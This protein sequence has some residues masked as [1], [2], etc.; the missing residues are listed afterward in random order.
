MLNRQ[1]LPLTD[2][3]SNLETFDLVVMKGLLVT[4]QEAQAI[5]NSNWSHVGMVVVAGDLQI[6]G[7]DPTA[8]L[9]W[10]AN[11]AD[12]ATDLLSNT[13]KAGPQLVLLSDRIQHN[14]WVKYDGAYM[15]RKLMYNRTPDMIDGLK[16]VINDAK[17]G[18]LP[19]TGRD[20]TAELTNFLEGRFYNIASAA[21]QY[22][23]S[24]LVAHTYMALGLLSQ[25]YVSNSYVPADFTEEVDV[26]LLK[27]A[28]L[29]REI[30]LDTNTIAP[31]PPDYKPQGA[32]S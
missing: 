28:W 29:G 25:Y 1:P 20:Q 17:N 10:E 27:G 30:Y 12:T 22:S 32:T 3:L 7:V 6:P 15:A 5:T 24:Q 26:S 19:Y 31:A 8:R 9:Y 2:F 18:T 14:F 16:A 11:T 21:G 23:C 13:I 4:S